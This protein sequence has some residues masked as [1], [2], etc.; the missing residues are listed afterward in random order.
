MDLPNWLGI[1]MIFPRFEP[2]TFEYHLICKIEV[3][4]ISASLFH[5]TNHKH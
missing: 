2:Y 4:D 5:L 3:R 1:V